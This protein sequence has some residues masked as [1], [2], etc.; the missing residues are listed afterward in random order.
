[1]EKLEVCPVLTQCMKLR[2]TDLA[3]LVK[4]FGQEL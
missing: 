3:G 4:R 1:M 2:R